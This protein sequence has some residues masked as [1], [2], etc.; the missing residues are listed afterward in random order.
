LNKLEFLELSNT[1]VSDAGLEHLKGLSNL[2]FLYL[3]DTKVTANG[4]KKLQ[5]ALPKCEINWK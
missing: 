2:E 1:K 5:T 4:A 3:T